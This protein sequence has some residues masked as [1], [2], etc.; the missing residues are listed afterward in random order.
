VKRVVLG[1]AALAS[2][3]AVVAAAACDGQDNVYD[4]SE[5]IR[6]RPPAQFVKGALPGSDP[7]DPDGGVS[8]GG[9]VV[10]AITAQNTVVYAGE[11]QKALGGRASSDAVS[12]GIRFADMGTGYWVLPLGNA[13]PLFPGEYAFSANSD[14]SPSIPPGKHPLRVVAFDGNGRPGAQS[15]QVL[16]VASRLPNVPGATNANDVTACYPKQNPAEAVFTLT[17]DADVDL[18]LHVVTPDGRDVNPKHPLVTAADAAP[19]ASDARIDRDSVA[20]CVPDGLRQEDLV[21]PKRPASG[22]IFQI[23]ANLFDGCAKNGVTFT[24]TVYEPEGTAGQDRHMVQTF[25]RSGRL[26]ATDAD[27]DALGLFIAEYPF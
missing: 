23:Y 16:C 18:D 11:G 8:P 4:Y 26:A 7:V 20:R 27:G 17:W 14:F 15:E 3:L 6:V 1:M 5:P 24:L 19:P 9:P 2:G 25:T 13:D 21:F 22:S 12:V 10:T